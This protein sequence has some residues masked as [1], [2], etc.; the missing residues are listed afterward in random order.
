ML[1]VMDA[2]WGQAAQSE[3]GPENSTELASGQAD[4][5]GRTS[6]SSVILL[7]SSLDQTTYSSARG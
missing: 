1:L 5:L 2:T 4:F 3:P 6:D 7:I